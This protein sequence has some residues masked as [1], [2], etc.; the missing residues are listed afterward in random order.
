MRLAAEWRGLEALA[1]ELATLPDRLQREAEGIVDEAAE[2][3]AAAVRPVF[4]VHSVTGN[5]ARGLAIEKTGPLTRRVVNRAPHAHLYEFGFTHSAGRQ[6]AGHNV[7][8][9]QAQDIRARMVSRLEGLLVS[10]ATR[11]GVLRQV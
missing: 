2:A 8:V 6:V 11:S 3:H 10:E 9:P 4:P 5:L 1:Q 7:Y